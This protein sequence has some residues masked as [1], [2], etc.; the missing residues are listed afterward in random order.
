MT[1]QQDRG[2][3]VEEFHK[4]STPNI[5]S[6]SDTILVY[7]MKPA[8]FWMTGTIDRSSS[9]TTA[10]AAERTNICGITS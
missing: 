6:Q 7:L 10:A 1:G 2:S 3:E 4:A 8:D 5:C 9:I